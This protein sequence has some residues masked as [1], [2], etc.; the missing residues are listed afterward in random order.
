MSN[1]I[2]MSFSRPEDKINKKN[3]K[4]IVIKDDDENVNE[5]VNE[6]VIDNIEEENYMKIN[7][8]NSKR[9]VIKD[10]DERRELPSTATLWQNVNENVIDNIEEENYMKINKS[11]SKRIVINDGDNDDK[12]KPVYYK[13]DVN[14][15]KDFVLEYAGSSFMKNWKKVIKENK[16]NIDELSFNSLFVSIP[17]G[18]VYYDLLIFI[19]FNDDYSYYPVFIPNVNTSSYLS[20]WS[21]NN[22]DDIND[23]EKYNLFYIDE[24]LCDI[25]PGFNLKDIEKVLVKS[26]L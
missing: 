8:S 20:L 1:Q 14:F 19:D 12:L 16:D 22:Y 26:L 18:L 9:I 6:N 25:A 4:R 11:N 10:D 2:E 13:V 5:N 17:S 23:D 15:I 3:S 21:V 24:L 7:K